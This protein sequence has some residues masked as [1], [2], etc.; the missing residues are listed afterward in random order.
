ME[1]LNIFG[2]FLTF[3]MKCMEYALQQNKDMMFI[4][5]DTIILDKLY[6]NN[7]YELGLS[8]QFIRDKYVKKSGY[9]NAGLI[10]TKNINV[11]NSWKECIDHTHSCAEQINMIKLR[12]YDYFEFGENYNLQTWRFLLGLEPTQTIASNLNI[13]NNKVYYKD[14]PLKFIHTH[15]NSQEFKQINDFFISKLTQAKCYKELV[16]IYRVINNKWILQIPKQPMNGLMRH[17]NDSYRELA[18]FI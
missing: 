12:D 5:S 7:S 17:K 1:N 11:L 6:I 3:K 14:K 2:K 10:W 18:F 13:R 15:F 16:I 9:Y 8:P 4:D